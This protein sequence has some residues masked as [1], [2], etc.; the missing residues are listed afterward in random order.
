MFKTDITIRD[1]KFM[2]LAAKLA[3]DSEPAAGAR[4]VSI[5]ALRGEVLSLGFNSAKT[6]PFQARFCKNPHALYWHAETRAIANALRRDHGDLLSRA[7]MYVLRLT[8]AGR[9][10]LSMPCCG[11]AKAIQEHNIGRV[12]YSNG[13]TTDIMCPSMEHFKI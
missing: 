6:H 10:A 11:C 1:Q 4:V 9:P 12:L 13:I 7:S 3:V 2:N 5:I 8:K